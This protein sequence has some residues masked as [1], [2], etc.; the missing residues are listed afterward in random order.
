MHYDSVERAWSVNGAGGDHIY[1]YTYLCI[2]IF[3]YIYVYSI[4]L[5]KCV[6]CSAGV[7]LGKM[8]LSGLGRPR[9]WEDRVQVYGFLLN[10]S[11]FRV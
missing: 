9:S 2:Y 8:R 1:I 5:C 3:I 10:G 6:M 7:S 4:Y 11:G